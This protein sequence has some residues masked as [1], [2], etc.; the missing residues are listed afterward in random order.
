MVDV[1]IGVDIARRADG[2]M[3]EQL[4]GSPVAEAR[5]RPPAAVLVK[6]VESHAHGIRLH[7]YVAGRFVSLDSLLF[8]L[9]EVAAVSI[10]TFRRLSSRSLHPILQS[11]EHARVTSFLTKEALGAGAVGTRHKRRSYSLETPATRSASRPAFPSRLDSLRLRWVGRQATAGR[12]TERPARGSAYA[13]RPD[14]AHAVPCA[15]QTPARQAGALPPP[16]RS[17]RCSRSSGQRTSTSST[18]RWG[19][20]SRRRLAS[21]R[22]PCGCRPSDRLV[23]EPRRACRAP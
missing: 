4:S 10:E 14:R 20:A 15:L 16:L 12:R 1:P 17:A 7:I 9:A 6:A 13:A 19:L 8:L 11:C 22:R 2:R 18:F 3:T 5:L 21:H 23:P